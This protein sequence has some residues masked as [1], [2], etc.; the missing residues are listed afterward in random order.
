MAGNSKK[1]MAV[2]ALGGNAIIREDEDGTIAQ[3]FRNTRMSL[4]GIVELI[5]QGWEVLITH[6]NG[7][8]VGNRLISN[9]M[10]HEMVP[11][12]PL[13]MLCGDTEGAMGYMIQQSLF[14]KLRYH[15]IERTVV[16]VITQTVI[17]P[18]DPSFESPT[19]PIGLFFSEEEKTKLEKE[20]RWTF[21][22]DAG[23]GYRQ[24]VPSPV[25]RSIV[26]IDVIKTLMR[27]GVIVVA[28]GGGGIPVVRQPD[29]TLEGR[30][31]II[32]KD[33][34]TSL[35]ARL[36]GANLFAM[37]TGVDKVALNYR[38]PNQRDIEHMT[39]G[40]ADGYLKE[41]HFHPGSMGP[42]I[43][44]AIEY[45]ESAKQG[46]VLITSPEMFPRAIRGEGGTTISP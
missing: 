35:S 15:A 12:L 17:D 11:D 1:K 41:G 31:C 18:I 5:H 19:K 37:I 45:L 44:A 46:K 39:K 16:T 43:R 7:P 36:L 25:P 42:K 32:D 14:N 30:D 3:Q 8:Q 21:V 33:L 10:A 22:E 20:H 13:G 40:E 29:G 24:V 38:K 6:G 27:A 4:V 34:A 9:E 26:E 23:R 2:I 28:V